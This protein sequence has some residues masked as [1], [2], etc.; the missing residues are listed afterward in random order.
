[1]IKVVGRDSKCDYVILDPQNRVSR[2]HLEI[3]RSNEGY[4]IKDL[5]SLNGTYVNNVKIE[6]NNNYLVKSTDKIT[7][8]KDYKLDLNSI[9]QDPDS[10][11]ILSHI[12]DSRNH[13]SGNNTVFSDGQ[14][15]IVF[16]GN[17]TKLGDV[18]EMETAAYVTIGRNKDNS[19]VIEK[20]GISR[21]QCKMRLLTPLIFEIV[22]LGS[23][24]GTFVD[25]IKLVPNKKYQYDSSALVKF[26]TD[27]L[28]D[29]KSVFPSIQIIK[30]NISQPAPKGVSQPSKDPITNAELKKFDELES[31]WKEYLNRQ[32]Q[33]GNSA[34]SY[35]IGGSVV[36]IVASLLLAPVT[37]GGSIAGMVVSAG[38]GILG[39]YL[40]QQKSS[41]IR[42]DLTYEDAFLQVYSCPRCQESFQKKPWI[43]IRECFKCKIRFR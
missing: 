35:G 15:T 29:L 7:L 23:T 34:M 31:I 18:L 30:K 9:F 27:F 5:S 13:L 12:D 40:G 6:S 33:A 24:N 14:K 21:Y 20:N 36:G 10:T 38:G 28:I 3:K 1:M 22:D 16:D 39:R 19:F 37:G 2:R 8:S 11:R 26:G 17:K 32:N 43:T 25:G 4:F 41:E 42:N